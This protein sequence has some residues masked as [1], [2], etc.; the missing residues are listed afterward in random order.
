MHEDDAYGFPVASKIEILLWPVKS[1]SEDE[2]RIFREPAEVDPACLSVRHALPFQEQATASVACEHYRVSGSSSAAHLGEIE[3][4]AQYICPEFSSDYNALG[5]FD[6]RNAAA[7]ACASSANLGGQTPAGTPSRE[8]EFGQ[9]SEGGQ[10]TIREIPDVSP[11]QEAI[12]DFL[13]SQL[14]TSFELDDEKEVSARDESPLD[15]YAEQGFDREVGYEYGDFASVAHV[16]DLPSVFPLHIVK[17]NRPRPVQPVTEEEEEDAS[18]KHA[19]DEESDP[20]RVISGHW[21]ESMANALKAFREIEAEDDDFRELFYRDSSFLFESSC[22]VNEIC[23]SRRDSAASANSVY[24]SERLKR[25]N[26]SFENLKRSIEQVLSELDEMSDD[27]VIVKSEEEAASVFLSDVKDLGQEDPKDD[28]SSVSDYSDSN[29][30][31]GVDGVDP[32][33]WI[34][35]SDDE[36]EDDSEDDKQET[37]DGG[38]SDH[39]SDIFELDDYSTTIQQPQAF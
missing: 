19:Q 6:D 24:D 35:V 30:D 33:R 13:L 16:R 4:L 1:M 27:E 22:I 10:P 25:L 21:E 31:N 34:I 15:W 5:G 36:D 12:M 38:V 18:V 28:A 37:G 20:E 9:G 3:D 2:L 8:Q 26:E 23:Y 7:Y 39:W 17:K 11:S 29:G 32:C 14:E